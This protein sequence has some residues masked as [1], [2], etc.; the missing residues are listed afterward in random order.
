[1]KQEKELWWERLSQTEKDSIIKSTFS[2]IS[3]DLDLAYNIFGS[4]IK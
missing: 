2:Q 4:L 1:M 3:F